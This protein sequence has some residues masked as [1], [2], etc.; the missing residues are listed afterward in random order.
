MKRL[1]LSLV[2]ILLCMTL[3]TVAQTVTGTIRGIVTDT[4]GAVVPGA[5]VT[6][7][8]TATGVATVAKSNQSGEYSIRFLQIGQ[9]KVAVEATGFS[10]AS[11]GPFAL[12]IDQ[13]A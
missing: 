7:T 5:T 1:S 6:A 11:Y 12:E 13:V 4:S 2:A 9:Y 10:K 3:S 8:N